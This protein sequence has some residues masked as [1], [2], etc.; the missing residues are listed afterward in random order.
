VAAIG[1]KAMSVHERNSLLANYLLTKT[2]DKKC[3]MLKI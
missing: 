2:K 1:E 3:G